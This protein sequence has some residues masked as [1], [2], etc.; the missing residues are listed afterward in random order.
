MWKGKWT[1]S[2]KDV[3]RLVC[4]ERNGSF[5]EP[6][7]IELEG[8]WALVSA[9]PPC[10]IIDPEV[11]TELKENFIC[12]KTGVA[13]FYFL[14]LFLGGRGARCVLFRRRFSHTGIYH[15]FWSFFPANSIAVIYFVEVRES[16]FLGTVS[17]RYQRTDDTAETHSGNHSLPFRTRERHPPPVLAAP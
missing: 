4:L 11:L 3:L 16:G 12:N 10:F 2:A 9:S 14:R 7:C 8:F 17:F 15:R 13:F 1:F 6:G 5:L